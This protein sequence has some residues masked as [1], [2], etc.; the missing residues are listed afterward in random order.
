MESGVDQPKQR[1]ARLDDASGRSAGWWA[2]R[3]WPGLVVGKIQQGW[4][5][6]FYPQSLWP[7]PQPV[8]LEAIERS[9]RLYNKYRLNSQHFSTR[10]E[11]LQAL[12]A[13]LEAAA[14]SS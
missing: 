14:L 12:D 2:L 5:F 1:L 6:Y 4:S 7:S 9:E 13:L 8:S 3:D 10:R 11:A